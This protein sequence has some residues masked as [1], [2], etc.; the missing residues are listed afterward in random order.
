[1]LHAA[2]LGLAGPAPT[3]ATWGGCYLA[4]SACVGVAAAVLLACRELGRP[5]LGRGRHDGELGEGALFAFSYST[6]GLYDSIDKYIILRI[7][8]PGPAGLYAAAYRLIDVA[9]TPMSSL[10]AATY[11]RFFQHGAEGIR[12]TLRFTRRILPLALAYG[13]GVGLAL[14]L[15]A[16]LLPMALG[17]DFEGAV[18]VVRWLAFLPLIRVVHC[19]AADSLTGAGFQGALSAVQVLVALTNGLLNLWL[20]PLYSWRGAA[21]ASLATDGL[22]ALGLWAS[23]WLIRRRGSKLALTGLQPG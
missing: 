4:A 10:F 23:V 18:E 5:G 16:P 3:A 15:A 19:F 6:E 8:A 22:L 2:W 9:Y 14:F 21:G 17:R 13:F 20:I 12:G 7:S 1:M 11:A